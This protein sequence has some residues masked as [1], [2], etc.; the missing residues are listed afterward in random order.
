MS[1]TDRPIEVGIAQL[2]GINEAVGVNQ[3]SATTDLDL[4]QTY[5]DTTVRPVAGE[6]QSILLV[7]SATGAPLEPTGWVFF[8]DADPNTATG[9]V[10][11]SAAERRTIIGQVEIAAADWDSDATG[12]SAYKALAV[13]FHDIRYLYTVFRNEGAAIN[14]A[15]GDDELI[16]INLWYRRDN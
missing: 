2:I 12:A 7:S 16:Q 13:P 15:G 3:F 10:A 9:D 11:I 6:V 1:M 4:G 14:D 8:F 5:G